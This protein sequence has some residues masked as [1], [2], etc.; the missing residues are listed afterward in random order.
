MWSDDAWRDEVEGARRPPPPLDELGPPLTR[1]DCTLRGRRR[2]PG[3]K[4]GKTFQ[5]IPALLGLSDS[6]TI[7]RLQDSN[8]ATCQ[9]FRTLDDESVLPRALEVESLNAESLG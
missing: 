5:E 8:L 1:Y 7:S 9:Y 6:N 2:E 4:A 3:W